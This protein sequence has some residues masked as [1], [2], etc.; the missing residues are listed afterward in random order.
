MTR[1]HRN[2][3]APKYFI[4][5]QK[6]APV[7]AE[8]TMSR[9]FPRRRPI[10]EAVTEGEFIVCLEELRRKIE[11]Q[12]KTSSFK[13]FSHYKIEVL[14]RYSGTVQEHPACSQYVVPIHWLN[15]IGSRERTL[16][17]LASCLNRTG[18]AS[19]RDLIDSF[20]TAHLNRL[21]TVTKLGSIS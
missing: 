19:E 16:S 17:I 21:E 13:S 3:D 18:K 20:P 10:T 14:T 9:K 8:K 1:S 6:N 11:E 12:K 2:C 5:D 15:Q 4:F 7:R